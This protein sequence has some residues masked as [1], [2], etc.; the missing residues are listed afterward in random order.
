MITT[1]SFTTF[2]VDATLTQ[3]RLQLMFILTLTG[4]TFL[5]VTNQSLPKILYLTNLVSTQVKC[6]CKASVYP[7]LR[8]Y[9]VG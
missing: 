1:L 4:V 5:M 2:S 8:T 3:N 6:Q 9:Q 7:D